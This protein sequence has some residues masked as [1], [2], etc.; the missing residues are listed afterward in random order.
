M[1]VPTQTGTSRLNGLEY[2]IYAPKE[3]RLKFK[4]LE[5]YETFVRLDPNNPSRQKKISELFCVKSGGSSESRNTFVMFRDGSAGTHPVLPEDPVR[6]VKLVVEVCH[7]PG[8]G[9]RESED[10]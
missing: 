3:E 7:T 2:H 1:L 10:E 6:R 4:N 8:G 9:P 5:H